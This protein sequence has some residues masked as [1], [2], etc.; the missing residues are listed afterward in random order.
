MIKRN[1]TPQI[2]LGLVTSTFLLS[3]LLLLFLFQCSLV[4]DLLRRLLV[5]V[6]AGGDVV[7]V[8]RAA[9]EERVG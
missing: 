6:A 8:A 9:E 4:S 3:F 7:E 1:R 5:Q 2:R